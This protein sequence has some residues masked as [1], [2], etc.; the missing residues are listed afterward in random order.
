[1]SD[2]PLTST[3]LLNRARGNDPAAW[4]RVVQL[5]RPLVEF[6]CRRAGLNPADAE[7]VAQEVF[8]AVVSGIERF[9]REREG[10]TFRGWLRGIA[11]HKVLRFFE[12]RGSGPVAAGGTAAGLRLHA[13][14]VDPLS[15]PDPV[16][17]E[18]ELYRRA[19]ELV[20]GEFEVP[21]WQAFWRT[22]VDGQSAPAVAAELG[23]SAAAVRQA[24]SRVLR[25][26]RIEL[27]E[28]LD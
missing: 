3:T 8:L 5:Y 9:R 26:L 28:L 25:R 23:L 4:A 21:T 18:Q 19:L 17:Q 24:K 15:E 1:M 27:G 12:K 7:D 22:A 11:R 20:R 10:D 6:W 16:E 13:V 2:A 14:A